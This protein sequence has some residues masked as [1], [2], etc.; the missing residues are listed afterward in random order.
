M[1][2]NKNWWCHR[3]RKQGWRMTLP[4]QAIIDILNSNKKHLSAE[5][6]YFI[7]HKKYPGIG[8]TT[9]YRTLELLYQM[10][11]VTKFDVG[12]KRA[13]YELT[14][15]IS[16]KHHHHLICT[17]CSAIIDYDDFLNEERKLFKEMELELSKKHH[18]QIH[19]HQANF[20]GL[21]NQCQNN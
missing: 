14:E 17:K 1:Q 19:S 5:D 2:V 20:Y 8:L 9:V 10:G 3:F 13:R 16:K 18:F 15:N 11:V 6:I 7:L 12:D 4:R 21:C